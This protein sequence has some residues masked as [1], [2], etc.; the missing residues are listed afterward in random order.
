VFFFVFLQKYKIALVIY[1]RI[2]K[3]RKIPVVSRW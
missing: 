1:C 3:T 2:N